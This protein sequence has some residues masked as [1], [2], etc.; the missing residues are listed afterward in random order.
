MNVACGEQSAKAST[1]FTMDEQSPMYITKTRGRGGAE[2]HCYWT[3]SIRG[4]PGVAGPLITSF[5]PH[6]WS[7]CN[8]HAFHSLGRRKDD[9]H[10]SLSCLFIASTHGPGVR[11]KRPCETCSPMLLRVQHCD[12]FSCSKFAIVTRFHCSPASQS[13]HHVVQYGAASSGS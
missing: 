2:G 7:P 12:T 13:S 10:S 11:Q 6:P 5:P 8:Y 4:T 3:Y 1:L 9:S